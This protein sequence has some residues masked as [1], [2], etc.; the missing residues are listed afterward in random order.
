MSRRDRF[1]DGNLV[2][3]R[4]RLNP[5]TGEWP[6]A[7][8]EAPGGAPGEAPVAAAAESRPAV[9]PAWERERRQALLKRADEF[10]ALRRDVAARLTEKLAAFPEEIRIEEERMAE[11]R[12]AMGKFAD[13]LDRLAA[14]DDHGWTREADF[15]PALGSAMRQAEGAR[16][17]FLR[18]NA[19]LA[20][21][22]RESAAAENLSRAGG[23]SLIPELNSLSWQ[24]GFRLG[25]ILGLPVILGAILAALIVALTFLVLWR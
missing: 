19:K 2:Q 5:A 6:A 24:Q 12:D 15:G 17:E 11:L 13:L 14:I 7:S 23:S 4:R 22:Q 1:I 25:L 21:L 18:I 8:A 9:D 3:I 16:L 10:R 20:A